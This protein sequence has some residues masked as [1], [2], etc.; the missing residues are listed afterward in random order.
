MNMKKKIDTSRHLRFTGSF[1][2]LKKEG[3]KFQK[4]Y[5]RNYMQWCFDNG[6]EFGYEHISVWKHLGGYVE[7]IDLYGLSKYVARLICTPDALEA[8]GLH[9]SLMGKS[10]TTYE[11]VIDRQSGGDRS[12]Q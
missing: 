2:A 9:W 4:L 5:A 11:F 7:I 3:F 8:T 6:E 12:I 1:S 10:W